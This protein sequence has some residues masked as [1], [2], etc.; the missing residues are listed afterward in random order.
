MNWLRRNWPDLLI[1]AVILLLISGFV[2]VLMGGTQRLFGNSNDAGSAG[3]RSDTPATSTIPQSPDQQASTPSTI[4]VRPTVSASEQA[5]AALAAAEAAAA[6]SK[7]KPSVAAT[8]SPG[9]Q[10]LPSGSNSATP[11]APSTASVGTQS[12]AVVTTTS[13]NSTSS[14]ANTPIDTLP[15][16]LPSSAAL[17]S[18]TGMPAIIAKPLN[19]PQVV[20]Q[21]VPTP[22][23]TLEVDATPKLPSVAGGINTKMSEPSLELAGQKP[24]VATGNPPTKSDYRISAGLYSSE[25]EAQKVVDTIAATGHPAF[26]VTSKNGTKIVLVGPFAN[27]SEADYAL[28]DISKVHSNLFVYVPAGAGAEAISK[29]TPAP[30]KTTTNNA[31]NASNASNNNPVVRAETKPQAAA[32]A[33]GGRGYLQ[34]G[35]FRVSSSADAIIQTLQSK[36]YRPSTYTGADGLIRVRVGPFSDVN[37][38]QAQLSQAG[39]PSFVVR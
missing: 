17:P 15:G 30:T 25:A 10:I 37:T 13:T 8:V 18:V 28:V 2:F 12:S 24:T 34:V 20:L 5:A 9:I 16:A 6:K 35:A 3:G 11:T 33:T 23:P 29:I 1:I 27:R 36:G 31:N 14:T 38:A 39:V 26:I 19:K 7:G 32:V 22:K 21:P 4:V